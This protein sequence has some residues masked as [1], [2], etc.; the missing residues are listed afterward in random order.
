M[1][2]IL[3][4]KQGTPQWHK[5][6]QDIVTGSIADDL[7]VHGLDHA[8][9]ANYSQFKG[10]YYT[11][12]GL[13]LEKQAIEIYEALH[14][15]KVEI[16]GMVKNSFYPNAGCSPD[17]IDRSIECLIEVKC[18]GKRHSEIRNI[19]SIPF[20][21]MSQLQFNMMISELPVARLVLYN[22]DL[23]DADEAYREIEVMANK[24]IQANMARKLQS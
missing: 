1:I 3:E 16:V 9:K 14:D 4:V 24:R 5:E 21:I 17:G 2:T 22:P 8:L 7:L 6:R 18:F 19:T 15:V 23:E 11:E 10:N 12:R 20:K 13:I